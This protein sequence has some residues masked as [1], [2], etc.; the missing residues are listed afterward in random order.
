MGEL[1]CRLYAFGST[2]APGFLP[3][4]PKARRLEE[5]AAVFTDVAADDADIR[6][7]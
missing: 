7:K 3:D 1:Y 6:V 2:L 4:G 5:G